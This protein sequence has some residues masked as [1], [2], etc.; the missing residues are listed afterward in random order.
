MSERA[1]EIRV[2]D[3]I[4]FPFRDPDWAQKLLVISGLFFLWFIPFL[5]TLIIFGYLAQLMRGIIIEGKE[6]FLP[7]WKNLDQMFNDGLKIMGV[8]LVY[9]M[10]VFILLMVGYG[11]FIVPVIFAEA[12]SLSPGVEII[13]IIS[14]YLLGMGLMGVGMMAGFGIG[15]I[16]PLSVC[17]V[18][19]RGEFKAAFQ[20]KKIGQILKANWSGFLVSYLL[21][22]G[23]AVLAYYATQ[24]LIFTVVLC[25]L[26]P[27]L[28]AGLTAYLSVLGSALFAD[29]YREGLEALE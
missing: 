7:E 28:V 16:V 12:F 8:Y 9:Y 5:P 21:F 13:S 26:Y 22:S 23:G 25:C 10:P 24:F 29:N 15:L 27:F 3:I 20:L 4:R 1:A 17:Q 19:A 2:K 18:V 11:G 14:G 6:P